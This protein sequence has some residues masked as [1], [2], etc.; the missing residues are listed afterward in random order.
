MQALFDEGLAVA[1]AVQVS[2]CAGCLNDALL[3]NG[4][5][6]AV[7]QRRK[8]EVMASATAMVVWGANP[9]AGAGKAVSRFGSSRI[10]N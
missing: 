9:G 5:G 1:N 7:G 8:L 3:Q 6:N 10:V 2:L 4:H